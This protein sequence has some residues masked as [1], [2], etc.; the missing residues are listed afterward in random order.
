MVPTKPCALLRLPAEPQAVRGAS[1]E[2]ELFSEE[3]ELRRLRADLE[4]KEEEL[5][6]LRAAL[7]EKEEEIRLRDC[8]LLELE[9]QC[10]EL[11]RARVWDAPVGARARPRADGDAS[12]RLFVQAWQQSVADHLGSEEAQV[13]DRAFWRSLLL[14]SHPDKVEHRQLPQASKDRFSAFFGL[15]TREKER[16]LA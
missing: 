16:L 6:R 3:E 2:L 7:E 1:A 9:A 4:E 15:V 5:R 13:A 14:C 11:H 12:V 10:K 8:V